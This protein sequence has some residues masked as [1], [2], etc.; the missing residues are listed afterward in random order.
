MSICAAQLRVESQVQSS[1]H[2]IFLVMHR[3]KIGIRDNFFSFL[4]FGFEINSL[5]FLFQL[6][7][8]PGC[9]LLLIETKKLAST[10][11]FLFRWMAPPSFQ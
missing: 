10:P 6:V 1:L 4:E 5:S 9:F 11:V 2:S 7:P 8:S 3:D